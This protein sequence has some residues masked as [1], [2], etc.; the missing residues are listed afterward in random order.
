MGRQASLA[1]VVT[2]LLATSGCIGLGVLADD[3]ES[4]PS[5]DVAQRY[6]SLDALEATRVTTV[7]SGNAT[8][9]TRSLVRV[10]LSG[11]RHRRYERVLSPASRAGDVAVLDASG[12]VLYDADENTV[13][14]APR[15]AGFGENW[16]A[17]LQR[18]VSAARDGGD[19]AEPSDGVS[20][21]PVVPTTG[22]GPSIPEDAIEGFEVEYLGTRTVD[23]RTAHG[24]ELTAVSEATLT[25][26]QT[27]WL[28]SQYY[29]PLQ[30]S[31]RFDYGNRTI[32]TRTR[33][34]NVTFDPDLPS[35]AFDFDVPENATV[36]E[37]N[38]S[39][40]SF[41]SANALAER[42]NFTVPE[43]EAPAGYEFEE[44]RYVGGNVTQASLQYVTADGEQLTV[45]KTTAGPDARGFAS[46]ENVT[47]AGRTGQYV[48][49]PRAAFV[50]WSC[51]DTH[52]AV[53]ATDLDKETLL[54]VADS[55]GCE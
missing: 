17:Y 43:P 42:V 10:D 36:T 47:V 46:G 44:A 25:I 45:T 8:N 28:D 3:A 34:E 24:F 9:V 5:V 48:T 15:T 38:A 32:E 12:M 14:H 6:D 20:P 49:T 19:V 18:V 16:S 35:G 37:T 27:L 39:T 33:L 30:T 2:V 51:G 40:Q 29:Y 50:S 1:V 55:A 26:D 54:A 53:V 7:D 22:S 41:N 4:P 11:D 13:T 31:H 52:Y 21:L 23:G